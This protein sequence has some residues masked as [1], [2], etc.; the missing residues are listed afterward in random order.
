LT[1]RE[2]VTFELLG[3][4]CDNRTIA[5][6]LEIS[7]RSVKRHVSA[8]LNKLDLQS[9]LQAGLVALIVSRNLYD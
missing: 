8:I 4:G 3:L 6:T 9:R 2:Y 7:E 5:R 1:P